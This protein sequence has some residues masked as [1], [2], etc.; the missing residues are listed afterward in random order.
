MHEAHPSF[1]EVAAASK[2]LAQGV[3]DAGENRLELLMVEVEE[4]RERLLHAFMLALG[5]AV[6]GLLAG[7]AFTVGIV[8]MFRDRSPLAALAILA[9]VYGGSALYFKARLEGLRGDW[10]TFSA[11]LDQLRKDRECLA[12]RLR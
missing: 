2:R 4:A 12:N 6:F 1:A 3:V 5:V 9:A 7:I 8:V 11:T 10:Q